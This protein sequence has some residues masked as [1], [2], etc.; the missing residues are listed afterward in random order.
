M[1]TDPHSLN[2][3]DKFNFSNNKK[4]WLSKKDKNIYS[5]E[6][7]QKQKF[8]ETEFFKQS[9]EKLCNK[10]ESEWT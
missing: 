8:I 3:E 4:T 5:S 7:N 2:F 6:A 10:K 9:I 1:P